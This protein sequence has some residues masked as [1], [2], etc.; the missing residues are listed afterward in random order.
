[1]GSNGQR[2]AMDQMEQTST[3]AS[4]I[5]SNII[6]N[7]STQLYKYYLKNRYHFKTHLIN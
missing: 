7:D 6:Y 3:P 5:D 2:F 4:K 1:M